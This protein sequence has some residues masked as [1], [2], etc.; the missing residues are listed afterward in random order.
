MHRNVSQ[1]VSGCS[2]TF[3]VQIERKKFQVKLCKKWEKLGLR[4]K[5]LVCVLIPPLHD[6]HVRR[7]HNRRKRKSQIKCICSIII[8]TYSNGVSRFFIS[9]LYIF[10]V[11]FSIVTCTRS[12]RKTFG[13]EFLV[14]VHTQ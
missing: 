10:T 4:F 3:S 8:S 7:Q 14:G 11:A 2:L 12:H 6:R 5:I 9:C 1:Y 13:H